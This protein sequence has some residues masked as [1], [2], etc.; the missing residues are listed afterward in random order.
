[1]TIVLRESQ[2]PKGEVPSFPPPALP[3]SVYQA[4]LA[5]LRSRAIAEELDVL[6][7]WGDREHSANVFYL[8]GFDPRFEEAIL[9]IDLAPGA[10]PRLLVG[11]ECLGFAS[12][13]GIGLVI[14]LWQEL[15]LMGQPRQQSRTLFEI[16]SQ[17]GVSLGRKVGCI[18]WKTYSNRLHSSETETDEPTLDL[19][20]LPAF[21]VDLLRKMVGHD[22][23]VINATNFLMGAEDGL[24]LICEPEQI[25]LF[26]YS[27]CVTSSAVLS[28]LEQLKPGSRED[29]LEKELD[30]R[31][32]PLS[33]HRMLGFGDKAR[34]GLASPSANTAVLGDAYTLAFGV[35]GALT[36]RAGVIASGPEEL[37]KGTQ[38]FYPRFVEN[39]FEVAQAWYGAIK[40]G[41]TGGEVFAA[42][43][44]ARD[45][46]LFEFALNPGHYLHLDEWVNSPFS[47]GNETQLRSGMAIQIDIIPVSKGPFVY[48]NIEDGIVLADRELREKLRNIDPELMK[49]VDNRRSYMINQLGFQ[50]DES[51]LPLG[52]TSGWL[53]P[54]VTNLS[55]ALARV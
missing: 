20:D 34:R 14:E 15:S 2:A 19:I 30:S 31:G 32:I 5:A 38:Q 51:V 21:L 52:N 1:M 48:A 22:G 13:P 26:E 47:S 29:D 28:L 25:R 7:V 17:E 23:E 4:R 36:C 9:I 54:Y 44:S 42:A 35:A 24:R 53:P 16:L 46:T 27:A 12:D 3:A 40:V 11:N 6:I 49:R 37:S 50:I 33:C 39:Y 18:G 55:L 43:E 45:K 41:A 8:T 10:S